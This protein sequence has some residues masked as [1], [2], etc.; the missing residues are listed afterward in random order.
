MERSLDDK[1]MFIAQSDTSIGIAPNGNISFA[2]GR[3]HPSLGFDPRIVMAMEL[4]PAEA[5]HLADM[6]LRKAR[7]AEGL[8]EA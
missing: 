4:T 3:P 8:P 7:M 6:L 2:I 5:R 1:V